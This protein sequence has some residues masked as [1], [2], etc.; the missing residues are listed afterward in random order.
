[1]D[2]LGYSKK[3]RTELLDKFNVLSENEFTEMV[4]NEDLI[5]A[6]YNLVD[7]PKSRG[8][9]ELMA[10]EDAAEALVENIRGQVDTLIAKYKTKK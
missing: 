10:D 3:E 6:V 4:R 2:N 8:K 7:S 5:D 1:M 9:Y